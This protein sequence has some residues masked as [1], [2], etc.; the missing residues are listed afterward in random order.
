MADHHNGYGGGGA[1]INQ[2]G[3]G[4]Y[5]MRKTTDGGL[6]RPKIRDCLGFVVRLWLL[7]MAESGGC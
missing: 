7:L 5:G 4:C 2:T 6:V 1:V 3:V